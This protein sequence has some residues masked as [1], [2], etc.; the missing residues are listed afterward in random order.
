MYPLIK[1]IFDKLTALG[2]LLILMPVC[3]LILFI[4]F[5]IFKGNPMFYQKRIGRNEKKFTLL[6]Y[7]TLLIPD[8]NIFNTYGKFLRKTHLDELPQLILIVLGQMSF[9]GPR[10]LLIDYL[11]Y[12]TTKEKTRHQVLPGILG[13]T[14]LKGGNTLSW[15]HRLRYDS[16]YAEKVCLK[17]DMYIL[18]LAIKKLLSFKNTEQHFSKSL[19]DERKV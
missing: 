1:S 11:P 9:I 4:S 13:L 3:L 16:F 6:K 19:I 8:S 17:L 10:P 18:Q 5:L 2:L 15:K 7:R 14:Q 12:Y